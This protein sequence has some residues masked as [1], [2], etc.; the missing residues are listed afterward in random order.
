MHVVTLHLPKSSH[1]QWRTHSQESCRGDSV[2][3]L[4]HLEKSRTPC[5]GASKHRFE[6]PQ[7][8][9]ATQLAKAAQILDLAKAPSKSGL[10]LP[11]LS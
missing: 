3:N 7:L 1:L 10:S 5:I 2:N 8:D 11:L 9:E 6:I 4:L